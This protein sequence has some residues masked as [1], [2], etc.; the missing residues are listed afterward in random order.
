MSRPLNIRISEHGWGI[1]DDLARK[2]RLP[3]STVV[4]AALTVAFRRI[5]EVTAELERRKEAL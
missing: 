4:K 3:W 2:H 5:P 1:V